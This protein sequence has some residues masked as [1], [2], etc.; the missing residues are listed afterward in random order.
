[1]NVTLRDYQETGTSQV[2]DAYK[3]GFRAPLLVVPTGGGKTIIFCYITERSS[4]KG[5]RVYI[6]VHR[7]ELLRQTSEK[8]DMFGVRHGC[9][10]P[11]HSMTGD[12]VQVASVQTLVRRLDKF[13][14][15]NL[16]V[17]DEAHHAT[18]GT[19]SKIL[20]QWPNA[21]L[22][23]VTATPIRL[24]GKGL[25]VKCG[26]FFD[27]LIEGPT[28]AE[29][30]QRGYLAEPVVYAPPTPLDL[31]Q[32]KTI[33]GDWQK[34]EL[35]KRVDKP[36]ITGNA[37]EHYATICPG[38]PAICFCVSVGH[39]E[40]V[41]QEFKLAGWSAESLD[42]TMADN[43][44]KAKIQG[45]ASGKIN[46][47]TSCDIISEGTDIPVVGAAILLRP[48]KSL[49]LDLQQVGRCLR[50]YE[51]KKNAII[52]DHV[53]NCYRHGMPDDVRNW[54]LSGS[55]FVK[56]SKAE[57]D[58]SLRIKQCEK[59]YAVYR[60]GSVACP[61]CGHIQTT[62]REVEQVDGMLHQVTRGPKKPTVK[63]DHGELGRLLNTCKKLGLPG[64]IAYRVALRREHK[65]WRQSL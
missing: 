47:L 61:Y 45:L 35:E 40:H 25:G 4:A 27:T 56:K 41:A 9:V 37:I 62:G 57:T 1:M 10:A 6:L 11:G 24:D 13:P 12:P 36:T 65:S 46:V 26:G 48:T 31:S 60:A 59:C 23:G 64:D 58:P 20:K 15:P 29:L 18:A 53:G 2:L 39:A 19:W 16:I 50:P 17:V 3:Q 38:V 42:G 49:G 7:Q 21:L 8:L 33:C 34:S 63:P 44:R 43:M 55:L 5:K 51:G 30:I 14:E 32:I 22:L 28:T 54:S 52:L